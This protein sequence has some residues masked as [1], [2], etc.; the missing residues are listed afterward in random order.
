M[1]FLFSLALFLGSSA[2]G[3][4]ENAA[5][6]ERAAPPTDLCPSEAPQ[7]AG[8]AAD[9]AGFVGK[10]VARICVTGLEDSSRKVAEGM[11]SLHAGSPLTSVAVRSDL[12][13]LSKL[14]AIADASAF[15]ATGPNDEVVVTYALTP[16]PA[17]SEISLEGA[18]FFDMASFAE[19]AKPYEGKRYVPDE[20]FRLGR[21]VCD[22]YVMQGYQDCRGTLKAETGPRPGTVRIRM[23]MEEGSATRLVD[24]TFEGNAHV[25]SG[26]LLKASDLAAPMPYV[27]L[28]IERAQLLAVQ[29]YMDRGYATARMRAVT[30]EG[31]S[32]FERKVRFVVEE[33]DAFTLHSV[34]ARRAGVV[35]DHELRGLIH[36]RPRVPFSRAV[37]MKDVER[38]RDHFAK[39]GEHVDVQLEPVVDLRARRISVTFEV[40]PAPPDEA[41]R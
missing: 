8:R 17:V 28:N 18:R 7:T 21:L 14:E 40:S 32:P 10:R 39:A 31:A 38:L 35:I 2:C 25:S 30:E 41:K 19:K 24:V 16:R 4:L 12:R 13:A 22:E 33:G 27:V 26:E 5:T 3:E 37:L 9:N 20:V 11:L 15:A 36:A 23:K 6:P 1:R 29:L 34:H